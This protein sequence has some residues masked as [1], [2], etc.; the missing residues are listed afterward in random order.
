M[1]SALQE[2]AIFNVPLAFLWIS[3]IVEL[4]P[5]PNMTYLAVLTLVEGRRAG[6][7][8]VAGVAAGLLLVGI[9]AAFGVA[10]F[11][12]ESPILYG[13]IRWLGVFYMLW[14]AYDIW[15]GVEPSEA[16]ESAPTSPAGTYFGRGFLTNV[17]NPKAAIFYIAVLPQFVDPSRMLLPQTLVLSV[18]YTF[19]ATAVHATI[20]ALASRMRPVLQDAGRMQTIRRI[21]AAGLV[22]VAIWLHWSTAPSSV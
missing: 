15:R 1:L 3:F 7:A 5:G 19:V 9:L 6:F 4:T 12:S 8:T 17:L 21:L 18:A 2:A 11:V 20:V 22:F 10:A 13:L 16:D 14:L